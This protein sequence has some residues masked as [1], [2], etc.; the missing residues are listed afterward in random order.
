M[1]FFCPSVQIG[2][3]FGDVRQTFRHVLRIDISSTLSKEDFLTVHTKILEVYSSEQ[4]QG[5]TRSGTGTAMVGAGQ[6]D[7]PVTEIAI[8]HMCKGRTEGIFGV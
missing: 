6:N 7:R 8:I 3:R 5:E 1:S 4:R 2:G